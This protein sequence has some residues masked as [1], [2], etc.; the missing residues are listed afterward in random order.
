MLFRSI[1][2]PWGN[3]VLAAAP[4][5]VTFAGW[6]NNGGGFQVWMSHG[7]NIYT[8]YNHM[9]SVAVAAGVRLIEAH[10]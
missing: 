5:V 8:T 9:S 1:A 2:A 10:E 6:K 3:P 7:N 4:G